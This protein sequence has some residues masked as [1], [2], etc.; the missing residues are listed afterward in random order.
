MLDSLP[1]HV[2]CHISLLQGGA[3]NQVNLGAK[4]NGRRGGGALRGLVEVNQRDKP[5]QG[6]RLRKTNKLMKINSSSRPDYYDFFLKE[7]TQAGVNLE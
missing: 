1:Q 3:D 4:V 2:L 5:P 7:A 6:A